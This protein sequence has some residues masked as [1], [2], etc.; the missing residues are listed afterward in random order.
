MNP[1]FF[2][3]VAVVSAT[4]MV[5]WTVKGTGA[6]NMRYDKERSFSISRS[7]LEPSYPLVVGPT[8]G[9]QLPDGSV[10]DTTE[11][12]DRLVRPNVVGMRSLV[13]F[14]A[15]FRVAVPSPG[16]V[17]LIELQGPIATEDEQVGTLE[18][19]DPIVHSL[20][21]RSLYVRDRESGR[22]YR[23]DMSAPAPVAGT[24]VRISD[25]LSVLAADDGVLPLASF[26]GLVVRREGWHLLVSRNRQEN[27]ASR[28]ARYASAD[29]SKA[30]PS[31]KR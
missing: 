1:W 8:G 6:R 23:L 30:P 25:S 21:E 19:T 4:I 5:W 7:G 31:A 16:H 29:G 12:H 2:A 14:H 22:R 13:R 26:A 3:G 10:L 27:A 9:V 24:P 15:S 17:G 18:L 11:Y 20:D 28:D